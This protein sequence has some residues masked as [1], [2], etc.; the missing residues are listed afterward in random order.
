LNQVRQYGAKSVSVTIRLLEVLGRVGPHVVR[1][2]DGE[3]LLGHARAVRDDGLRAAQNER[4]RHDIE[5]RHEQAAAALR[6]KHDR[7]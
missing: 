6:G 4:D 5:A 7:A 2:E 3:V 1:P